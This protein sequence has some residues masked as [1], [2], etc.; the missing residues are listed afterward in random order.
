MR[1]QIYFEKVSTDSQMKSVKEFAASFGHTITDHS[2]TPI[3]V[4]YRGTQRIAYFCMINGPIIVPS[5]HPDYI[6]PRN[7][8]EVVNQIRSW[9][10]LSTLGHERWP[11]GVAWAAFDKNPAIPR[12]LIEKLGFRSTA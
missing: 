3:V 1:D 2:L 10:W 5:F 8:T 9:L 12:E 11:Q 4:I 7:F 6:T